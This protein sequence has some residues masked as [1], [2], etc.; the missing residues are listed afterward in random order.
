MGRIVS[1][2][3]NSPQTV[4][5]D[6][7]EDISHTGLCGLTSLAAILTRV[8]PNISLNDVVGTWDKLHDKVAPDYLG[9]SEIKRFVNDAY[10]DFLKTRSGTFVG[11]DAEYETKIA[12]LIKQ[13]LMPGSHIITGIQIDGSNRYLIRGRGVKTQTT[14]GADHWIVI[15]GISTQWNRETE[16]D[17]QYKWIRIY[18]PFDNNTEYYWWPDFKSSWRYNSDNGLV[19]NPSYLE[20]SIRRK[21]AYPINDCCLPNRPCR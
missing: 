8:S 16:S 10:S 20:V 21:T 6:G 3:G 15:T 7:I 17:S 18:N 11:T 13:M 12:G 4:G 9:L 14:N 2:E 5:R 19:R 1:P